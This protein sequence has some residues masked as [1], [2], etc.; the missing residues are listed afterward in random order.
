M[1]FA[2]LAV[3]VSVLLGLVSLLAVDLYLHRKAERSAGLNVWGYRGPLAGSKQPG[4]VRIAFLGG[5]TMFGYGVTWQEAIPALVE[6]MLNE[7]GGPPVR[8]VNL[9]MNNE[10]AYSFLY[11]LQD[12]DY[13]DYD[14]A[15]LYE[16]YNDLQG[17]EAG[18]NRSLFRHDSPVFRL[19]GYYPILPLVLQERAMMLRHGGD[20]NAA[21]AANRGEVPQTV[22]RPGFG[23]RSAAAALEAATSVGDSLSRGL[24][25]LAEPAVVPQG[26]ADGCSPPWSLYCAWVQRAMEYVLEQGKLVAV[27]RQPNLVGEPAERH[28]QQQAAL[29]GMLRERYASD[30]RVIHVDLSG[31][32]D[33]ANLDESFDRMHL[34]A[35]GNRLAADALAAALKPLVA[36]AGSG[37][38]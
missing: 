10:G 11:T 3:G 37:S 12:Y 5:S 8:S 6:G 18:G 19:T 34:T 32:A 30:P 33:L 35:P 38:R 14:I 27:V 7:A 17:E 20:L 1:L 23:D 4:E 21:Y 25:R 36:Q 9:A 26:S 22:F 13:L 24:E 28:A 2:V 15:V 31:V 29:A 16:G